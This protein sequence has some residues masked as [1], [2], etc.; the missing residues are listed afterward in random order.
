MTHIIY[1]CLHSAVSYNDYAK[2]W[3]VG[4]SKRFFSGALNQLPIPQIP[5]FFPGS[6]V[7][8]HLHL[9]PRL[10]IIRG[11]GQRQ[12]YLYLVCQLSAG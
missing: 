1:S 11:R 5:G 12:L 4:R 9:V 10:K 2:G 8:A 7:A 6:E 3:T